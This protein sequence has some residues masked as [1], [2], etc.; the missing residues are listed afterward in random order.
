[1]G[2][3]DDGRRRQQL[4]IHTLKVIGPFSPI[5]LLSVLALGSL[6]FAVRAARAGNIVRHRA[7]MRSLYIFA[8]ILTGAFTLL[9]GR[10]MHAV[11]FGG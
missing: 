1:V 10:A 11:V 5:H 4:F 7:I 2:G 9:P 6:W 3:D 8:L